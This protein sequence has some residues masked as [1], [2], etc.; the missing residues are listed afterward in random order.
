MEES[1][2]VRAACE[3]NGCV[4]VLKTP[5]DCVLVRSTLDRLHLLHLSQQEWDEFVTA[6]K[7]GL[8][9]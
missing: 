1:R 9:D 2:W 3:S 4:E 5:Q 6:V 7:Q 8:F